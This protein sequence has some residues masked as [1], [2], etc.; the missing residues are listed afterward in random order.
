MHDHSLSLFTLLHFVG[1]NLLVLL[2]ALGLLGLLFLLGLQ[3]GLLSLFH[4]SLLRFEL[5]ISGLVVLSSLSLDFLETQTNDSLLNS[6]CLSGSSLLDFLDLG[7][8]VE[9]S[10]GLGPG[11][12]DWLDFLVIKG[13]ALLRNEVMGF[14][15]LRNES[16]SVTWVNSHFRELTEICLNNHLSLFINNYHSTTNDIKNKYTLFINNT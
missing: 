12:L 1:S 11:E 15:V 6:G 14:S 8:S 13:S 5:G 9:S 2:L 10:P 4:F 3:L 16:S 7:F